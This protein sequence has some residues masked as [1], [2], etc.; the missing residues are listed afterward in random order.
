MTKKQ[1]GRS[2]RVIRASGD[3]PPPTPSSTLS[4]AKGA[5][6]PEKRTFYV[7][8]IGASAGGLEALEQLF[9]HMPP[10]SGMAFVIVQHLDPSK[11]SSMAEIM[12]RLTTMPVQMAADGMKVA[13]DSVYLIPP[14]RDM[15]IRDGTLRLQEMTHARGLRLPVDFFLRSLARER[16]EN[17]ICIILSGT[18]SDGALGLRDIKAYLGTVFV[19]DPQ[20]ARYDGMPRSAIDT[21]LADFVMPPEDMPR[22]LREFVRHLSV[23]GHRVGTETGESAEPLQQVFASLRS[24]TGHDFSGY[25][26]ATI[27]RRLERRMS[28]NGIDTVAEY[29]RFLEENESEPGAL[30]KDI[31]ISVTS[32]F[33]DSEAFEALKEKLKELVKAKGAGSDL[34]AW[35]TGCATGGEAYSV[36]M[37]ISEC[38]EPGKRLQVQVFAT[39]MNGDALNVARAGMYPENIAA[40]V[41]PARL[42]RFFL[43]KEDSYQVQREL[44]EMVSFAS[45]DFIKDP[46]FSKMDLICCRNLLIYLES[47]V[48]KRLLPLLHH[49]LRPG[50]ILFLGPSETVGDATDLFTTLDRKWKIFQRKEVAVSPER[51]KFH[52]PFAMALRDPAPEPL[53]GN[54]TR[55]PALAEKVFLDNYAPTFAVIDEKYRL[56]YVRGRT[57]KYLEIASGQPS[58]SIMEM[59]REGLRSDLSSVIYEATAEKKRVFRE[60][61]RV[62][63][64]GGFQT[65]N[66]TVVPL[67]ERGI[68]PGLFMVVFQEVGVP[69]AVAEGGSG[70]AVGR[71]R[72]AARAEEELRNTRET[73]QSAIEQLEAANEELRSAN[74][75]LQSNNEE[76]QS[77]NEELDTSREELQSLNEEM[78]TVNAELSN[79]N[80][81]LARA[82]DDL[83][84]YLDR[85]DI[86]IIFLDESL[87]IRSFT[88]ATAEVFSIRDIDI[89]RPVEEI[90]SRLAYQSFVDDARTVLRTQTPRETEV[91]RKDGRWYNMRILPYLTVENVPAGLVVSFLDIDRQKQSIAGL[92]AANQEIMDSIKRLNDSTEKYRKLF[93]VMDQGFALA[94]IILDKDGKPRDYRLTEVNGAFSRMVGFP[95]ENLPG[96]TA[97]ELA[98][99]AEPRWLEVLGKVAMTGEPAHVSYYDERLGRHF[100][101]DA[102]SPGK[103]H[104]ARIFR[105]VTDRKK[106]EEIETKEEFIGLISHEM[107]TPL[108]VML[109]GLHTLI[110]DGEHLSAGDRVQLLRDA[111]IEAESLADTVNNL[112]EMT[113][114]Q[115]DRTVLAR[116]AVDVG[117]AAREMADRAR[118]QHPKHRFVVQAEKIQCIDCDRTRIQLV[119]LNLLDNA[120]KYSPE[121]SVVRAFAKSKDGMIVVSVSDQGEGISPDDQARLF[122]SFERLGRDS[123]GTTGGTGLGLVV[124]KRLVE[125]HGGRLWVESDPGKGS[126]FSFTLPMDGQKPG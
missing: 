55:L 102:Y 3:G 62:K 120:A 81:L 89:G 51:L 33:R 59:A 21:G 86:A 65:V 122:T 112:L 87:N 63:H 118:R 52:S 10:D 72:R 47:E 20:T 32:F 96:R 40:D 71:G 92:A 121:G 94:E 39:D 46:L 73:L 1:T 69:S 93:E 101:V 108:T 45:H 110:N 105:D 66:L 18:G 119:M 58:L 23:N 41:A 117:K 90:T 60:G 5:G 22:K 56:V 76:L 38:L 114:A 17:A 28:V 25:R 77:T 125:A 111:Y 116:E 57:G 79:T 126:T 106:A 91:Q 53:A 14:D 85:T 78:S 99:D 68:P 74:E 37:V 15:G 34:R 6:L 8:G 115:A 109:G 95:L 88:P 97:R 31:L 107:K 7:T 42:K 84:N 35:V 67:A 98:P 12:S 9:R 4:P 100:E 123:A 124:A 50:G 64:D 26:Q 83:K 13:P 104:F 27:R 82:S 103:G 16:G 113:R 70:P 49:A 24:T 43:R 48:Q 19:Q 54:A 36:A 29:A 75:E 61:V 80:E 2:K 44:R 11:H 30:L